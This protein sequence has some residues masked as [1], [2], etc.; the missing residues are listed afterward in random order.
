[1]Y[2]EESAQD[3]TVTVEGEDYEAEATVDL[4]G[5]GVDDT[6]VV[7][8]EDGAIAFTDTGDDGQADLM[9]RV[10]A[11]GNIVGQ[12]SFDESTGEWVRVDEPVD[13]RSGDGAD[14]ETVGS[15]A[16]TMTVDTPDGEV[17]VGAPTHDTTGDGNPDSVVVRNEAGNTVIF[18][19]LNGDG[20]ADY[21][22]EITE[23]GKVTISEHTGDGEWT[24]VEEGHINDS[25][26]YQR[27]SL[28]Q[29]TAS[30]GGEVSWAA[31]NVRDV[32]EVRV[33][34]RTGSWV[35]GS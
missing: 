17:E 35:R 29:E 27:D 24:V 4:T 2:I 21:S 20:E 1:M 11:N 33:D 19:D 34:P 9:T 3:I 25:G 16:D 12:A 5:D 30:A 31:A 23:A 32:A 26:N 10:D 6:A 14:S 8:T 15:G 7:E 28:V 13:P 22:T 18:T